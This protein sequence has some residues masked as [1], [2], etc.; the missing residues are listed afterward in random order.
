M[1]VGEGRGGGYTRVMRAT[2]FVSAMLLLLMTACATAPQAPPPATS[3]DDFEIETT[4]IAM[5]NVI[6]G[7]A[8]RRDWDRMRELF[9]PG[10]RMIVANAKDGEV[11]T[12]VMT[13][14]EYEASSKPYFTDIGFFERPVASRI[15]R[16]GDIAHVFSTYESRHASADE[17]P[18]TRG[19]NSIQLVR[20]G[21][22]WKI[23]TVFWQAED[24]THPIARRGT[25][26]VL[27]DVSFTLHEREILGV[28]GPN[29]AG[30]TT[31]FECVAGVLP[32]TRGD[33]EAAAEMFYLPDAIRPWPEQSVRWTIDFI[34]RAFDAEVD[35]SLYAEL[36][37]TPLLDQRVGSLSKGEAKRAGIALALNVPRPILLLDEPFDGLD[38]R[39]TRQAGQLLRARAAAGRTLVLSIHQLSDAARVCDRFLLLDHGR[40]VA[41]GTLD[42]LTA[43]AGN[44]SGLEEVFLALT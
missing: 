10:A 9:V 33:I 18:F 2:T 22:H 21:E 17:Q 35:E 41:I 25:R 12:K 31:L 8:G 3:G 16:F 11:T 42:E 37:L 7:P 1:R 13:L 29:G 26:D 4:V 15:E 34:A 14:E 23:V 28:I 5:Y 32:R 24:A 44:A 6:S 43:Q 19:I 36:D 39:Q 38:L 30:K 27:T 20:S 40:T